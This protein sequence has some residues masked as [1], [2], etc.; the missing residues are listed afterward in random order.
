M[1]DEAP[2]SIVVR[3]KGFWSSIVSGPDGR[4]G[5]FEL[6]FVIFQAFMISGI[7]YN[8]WVDRHF[9]LEAAVG[10]EATLLSAYKA[11]LAGSDRLNRGM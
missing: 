6:A 10:M 5:E 1:T 8:T 4:P 9:P 2:I 7:A 3:P 11:V